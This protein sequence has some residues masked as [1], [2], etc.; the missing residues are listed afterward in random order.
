MGLGKKWKEM[1]PRIE[2]MEL[3]AAN[4]KN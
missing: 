2:H 4:I 1:I 3:F